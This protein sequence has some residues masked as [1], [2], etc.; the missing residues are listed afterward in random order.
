VDN[1]KR[2]Q[3]PH[4]SDHQDRGLN[5]SKMAEHDLWIT[6]QIEERL[7]KMHSMDSPPIHLYDW[8]QGAY[9][10]VFKQ[11]LAIYDIEKE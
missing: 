1:Y 9:P 11:W 3:V 4:W 6:E 10:E 8:I 2:H 5:M 7:H